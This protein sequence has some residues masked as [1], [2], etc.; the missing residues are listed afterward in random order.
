M[1]GGGSFS[2]SF[3]LVFRVTAVTNATIK[4]STI[5]LWFAIVGGREE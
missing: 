3:V 2:L 5:M 1:H 4:T